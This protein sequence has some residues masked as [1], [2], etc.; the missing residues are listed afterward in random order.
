[1]SD[2]S[3]Q[4]KSWQWQTPQGF[5]LRG[6]HSRPRNLP[7]LHFIHGNSY[8]GLTYLPLWQELASDFD[9]FLH[10]VQGH[11]DSDNGDNFVG[12][13][14]CA[15][16]ALAAWRE[17][18]QPVFGNQV[19]YG[20]GHSFGGITTLMMSQQQPQ[21]FN[22]LLLLDPILFQRRMLL[23]MRLLDSLGLYRFNPY[24]RRALKRRSE[25]PSEEEALAGLSNRGMFRNWHPDAL[26]AYVKHAMHLGERGQWALKCPPQREA[27]LFSSYAKGLWPYLRELSVP[28]QV[29]MGE[30]T[31]PFA[32]QAAQRWAGLT[33]AMQLHWVP[34]KHCFM[35]ED[36][37]GTA[38]NIRA[39]VH[40]SRD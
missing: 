26:D 36:P 27:E 2:K 10:D 35:Q 28:T 31:Y 24:A 19:L 20:A 8:N 7:V 34:G 4:W 38:D 23:P 16:L 13:N 37:K 11:G 3:L 17:A 29:W 9:F 14:A 33:D 30:D 22:Q 40:L 12:W 18:G 21:L 6:Q 5:T 32:R 39:A 25:W 1:M 15:D